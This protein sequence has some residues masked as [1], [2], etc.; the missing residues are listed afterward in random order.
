MDGERVI[1]EVRRAGVMVGS[2]ETS[3]IAKEVE[4]EPKAIIEI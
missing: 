4:Q 1:R 2:G 3:V